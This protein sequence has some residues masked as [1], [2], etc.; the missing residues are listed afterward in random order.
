MTVLELRPAG[1]GPG[2]LKV[3]GDLPGCRDGTSAPGKY[4]FEAGIRADCLPV[5][6]PATDQDSQLARAARAVLAELAV[7]LAGAPF[8]VVLR[9]DK[10]G[11]I[12]RKEAGASLRPIGTSYVTARCLEGP[13]MATDPIGTA[14]VQRAPGVVEGAEQFAGLLTAVAYAAVPVHD[15]RN[16]HVIG[17]LEMSSPVQGAKTLVIALAR[18]VAQEIEERLLDEVGIGDKAILYHFLRERHRAKGPFVFVNGRTMVPNA[19]ADRLLGPS[20]ED[21]LRHWERSWLSG[22]TRG[23]PR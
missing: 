14:P 10:G 18:R 11:V 4:A 20:D 12:D 16:G 15:R 9:D 22:H 17:V 23:R 8:A 2:A 21:L 5:Q 7:D 13:V 3:K 6:Q 19:A 1:P